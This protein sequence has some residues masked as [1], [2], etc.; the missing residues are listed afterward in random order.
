MDSIPLFLILIIGY[1][2]FQFKQNFF[3][4]AYE[5]FFHSLV[6]GEKKIINNKKNIYILYMISLGLFILNDAISWKQ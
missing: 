4:C 2:V 3:E 1:I 5:L 6:R